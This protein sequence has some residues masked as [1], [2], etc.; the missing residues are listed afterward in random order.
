MTA[1][2]VR[3]HGRGYRRSV[4]LAFGLAFGAYLLGGAPFAPATASERVARLAFC[5]LIA[6]AGLWWALRPGVSWNAQGVTLFYALR[7]KHVAWGDV[8]GV[9][10]VARGSMGKA[11]MLTITSGQALRV[12]TVLWVG[13]TDWWARL[14]ESHLLRPPSGGGGQTD[15]KTALTAKGAA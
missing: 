15:A 10:W 13:G 5:G 3:Y 9:D 2:D 8:T 11:L 4:A 7:R 6:A 14:W 1:A 12:P